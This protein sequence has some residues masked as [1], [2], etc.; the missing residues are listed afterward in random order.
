MYREKQVVSCSLSAVLDME[1]RR[2]K[3]RGRYLYEN[4]FIIQPRGRF[5]EAHSD[6]DGGGSLIGNPAS[7]SHGGHVVTPFQ[8]EGTKLVTRSV[9]FF[10]HIFTFQSCHYGQSRVVTTVCAQDTA[11][12]IGRRRVR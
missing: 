12:I 6:R 5:D 7:S 8:I 9:L 2:V 3:L 11:A 1:Y 10:V 4:E